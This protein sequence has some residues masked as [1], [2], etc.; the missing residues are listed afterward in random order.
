MQKL[1]KYISMQPER[2]QQTVDSLWR[3]KTAWHW[4]KRATF[5]NMYYISQTVGKEVTRINM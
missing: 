3:P 1:K 2:G 5:T 4:T